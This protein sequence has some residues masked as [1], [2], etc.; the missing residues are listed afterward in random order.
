MNARFTHFRAIH[1]VS[2]FFF[3]FL[4]ISAK[5]LMKV[6]F[7]LP[8]KILNSYT[9]LAGVIFVRIELKNH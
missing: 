3:T 9:I 5:K 2:S 7:K 8:K 1:D 4:E 6:G